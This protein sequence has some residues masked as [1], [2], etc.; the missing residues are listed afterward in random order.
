MHQRDQ[1]ELTEVTVAGVPVRVRLADAWHWQTAA[2][3]E[4][5]P[6]TLAALAA[7]VHEGDVVIDVGAYV[8]I[9]TAVAAGRGAEVHCYE[10]DPVSRERLELMLGV[11]PGLAARVTVHAEALGG[12]DET[13]RLSS[14]NL[15]DSGSSLFRNQGDGMAVAVIDAA[16]IMQH[17]D[18]DRCSLLKVDVE[19]AEYALL[20]RLFPFLRRVQPAIHLS[21]HTYQFRERFLS[22]PKLLRGVLYR[23]VALPRQAWLLL[24][25]SRLGSVLVPVPGSPR[26]VRLGPVGMARVLTR[27]GE[28]EFLILPPHRDDGS[29][30]LDGDG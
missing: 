13:A 9:V 3:G 26:W 15:G 21:T 5:E 22:L 1:E 10:P 19:G 7:L 16:R 25:V 2:D 11:N 4:W 18:F 6:F 14:G 8:G 17:P 23:L 24:R 29:L 27:P 20:P 28:K 12:A 30:P